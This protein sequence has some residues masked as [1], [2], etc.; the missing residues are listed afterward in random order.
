MNDIPLIYPVSMSFAAGFLACVLLWITCEKL[1]ER[2][3]R[4]ESTISPA[5]LREAAKNRRELL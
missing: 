3:Q 1:A 4:R 2:R 5:V